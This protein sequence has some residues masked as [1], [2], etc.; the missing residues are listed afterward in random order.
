MWGWHTAA[1]AQI[2][3]LL[4]SAQSTKEPGSASP[5]G[6]QQANPWQD[7]QYDMAFELTTIPEPSLV[8]LFGLGMFAVWTRFR[9][10]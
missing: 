8:A 4:G 10:R 6:G 5:L 7:A 1:S 3:E 2:D 9:R